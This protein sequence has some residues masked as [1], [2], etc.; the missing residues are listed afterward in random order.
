MII[1]KSFKIFGDKIDVIF[2]EEYCNARKLY[3]EASFTEAK[4][5]LSTTAERDILSQDRIE[6]TFYH[7]KVHIILDAMKE[8]ELSSNEKFVDLFAKLLRQSDITAE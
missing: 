5:R 4:I 7:E 1:P 2:D 6:D 3:G 8:H